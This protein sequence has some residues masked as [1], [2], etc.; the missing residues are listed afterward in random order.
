V[1]KVTSGDAFSAILTAEGQVFTWGN[2]VFGQLGIDEELVLLQLRPNTDRP[3]LFKDEAM[4]TST[5]RI[6][7]I[8]AGQHSMLALTDDLKVFVWGQR[9]GIY[10]QIELTLD[11]VEQKA[12]AL[13]LNEINQACPR[14]AKNNLI[15]H[16]TS[17]LLAGYCNHGLITDKGELLVQ[18][19]NVCGQLL[20]P[21]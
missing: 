10:P 17:K 16:K 11:E 5:S 18:G 21:D 9:M 2:N 7:D 1:L 6:I 3:L 19:S 13:E 4:K 14:L 8:A 15:F 20:L 12:A